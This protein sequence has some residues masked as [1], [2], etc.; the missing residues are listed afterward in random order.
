MQKQFYKNT[1][2]GGEDPDG[3]PIDIPTFKKP[4][5]IFNNTKLEATEM[6]TGVPVI[7]TNKYLMAEY[8]EIV[9]YGMQFEYFGRKYKVMDPEP[10]VRFGGVVC[11]R[12]ELRDIT[13]GTKHA[14]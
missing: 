10:E 2:M 7:N 5:R 6:A 14:D 8:D 11:I 1:G 3:K 4:I 13:Q 9:E 12:A